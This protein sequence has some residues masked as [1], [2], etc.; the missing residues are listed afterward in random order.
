MDLANTKKIE[1]GQ[2]KEAAEHPNNKNEDPKTA[3]VKLSLINIH[4]IFVKDKPWISIFYSLRD[5]FKT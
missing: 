3:A 1:N 2:P 4:L 5:N